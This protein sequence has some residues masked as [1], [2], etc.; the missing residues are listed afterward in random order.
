MPGD[1]NSDAYL[2]GFKFGD[3][4]V[5]DWAQWQFKYNWR[6]IEQDAWLDILPDSDFFDGDTG[7]QGHEFIFVFGLAKNL[8]LGFDYYLAETIGSP[9]RNQDLLQIDLIFKF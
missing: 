2:V 9:N 3:K 7:V 5:K 1:V 8:T 4:K 6:R